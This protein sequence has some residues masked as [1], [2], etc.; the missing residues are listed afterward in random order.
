MS[1]KISREVSG[2]EVKITP[3]WR[4]QERLKNL[5]V[6]I[7]PAWLVNDELLNIAPID[8]ESLLEMVV[9]LN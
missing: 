2:S 4:N 1:Q 8:Y 6:K 9:K 7:L 3:Y 5:G